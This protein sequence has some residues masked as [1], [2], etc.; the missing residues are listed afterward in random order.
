MNIIETKYW[1][2]NAY[3][4]FT[5]NLSPSEVRER[6]IK[7][8]KIEE[9]RSISAYSHLFVLSELLSHL[10]NQSDPAFENCRCAIICVWNHCLEKDSGKIKFISDL[11]SMLAKRFLNVDIKGAEDSYEHISS[12]C[13][14]INENDF[15]K[16]LDGI[17]AGL[18]LT[19]KFVVD[20]K[21]RFIDHYKRLIQFID[22]NARNWRIYKDNKAIKKKNLNFLNSEMSYIELSKH[23]A[24]RIGNLANIKMTKKQIK[25]LSEYIRKNFRLHL[26][27]KIEIIRRMIISGFDLSNKRRSNLYWDLHIAACVFKNSHPTQTELSLVTSDNEILKAARKI[28]YN[29]EVITLRDYLINLGYSKKSGT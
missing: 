7:L 9:S 29:K 14:Y 6:I 17:R 23:E 5:Y 13:K 2:T 16:N 3:R 12:L 18:K 25:E 22:P 11:D 10:A 24:Q 20:E 26:E 1:D 21:N 19:E 4:E 15:D 8:R 28:G 27:L